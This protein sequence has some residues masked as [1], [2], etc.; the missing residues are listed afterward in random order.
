MIGLTSPNLLIV[1]FYKCG[2]TSLSKYLS[3]HGEICV[4]FAKELYH[5]VD[6][7]SPFDSMSKALEKTADGSQGGI[8]S[9]YRHR[10]GEKYLLDA[11]PCYYS[12]NRAL[13]YAKESG[14]KVIFTIRNPADRLLSSFRYFKNVYQEYPESTYEEFV[15]ALF[16]GDEKKDLYL[17]KIKKDFFK[18]IFNLELEMGCYED[19]ITRWIEAIGRENIYF[20]TLEEMASQP[21]AVMRKICTFLEISSDIYD[22]YEFKPYMCSYEVRI[23]LFQRLGR[24][25]FKEDP[26]RYTQLSKYHSNF[27]VIKNDTLKKVVDRIYNGLLVKQEKSRYILPSPISKKVKDYYRKTNLNLSNRY[28]IEYN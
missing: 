7:G 8:A 1:G 23:P 26:E 21:K 6:Q 24:K 17:R 20:G 2:T 5:Y 4:P 18:E 19:H 22:T 12:Q 13:E 3:E 25:I 27:H 28:G 14:S 15:T 10:Q 11:T 9:L 16:D